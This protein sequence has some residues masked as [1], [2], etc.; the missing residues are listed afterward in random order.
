MSFPFAGTFGSRPLHACLWLALA[1]APAPFAATVGD[2]YDALVVHEWGTFTSVADENGNLVDWLPLTGSSDLPCFVNRLGARNIKLALGAVRMETPVLYF[3]SSRPMT[4]AVH[5][6]FPQGLITEWYPQAAKVESARFGNTGGRIQWDAVEL[7]PADHPDFPSG[8][9]ASHYYSARQ[10]DSA[11]ILI[12]QQQ[13]KM[14]FYRGMGNVP[15]PLQPHFTGG[16][17][18]EVRNSSAASIPLVI[19]FEN[20]GGKAG[21]KVARK[22][23]TSLTFDTNEF[24]ADIG[25]LRQEMEDNLVAQGLYP[26]EARAMLETWRESWFEEGTRIFYF[27]PRATVDSALPLTITPQPK[28]IARVFVGRIELLSPWLEENIEAA[29][30]IGDAPA[31]EKYGRFLQPFVNQISHKHASIVQ[32]QRSTAFLRSAYAKIQHEFDSPVCLE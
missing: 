30:T 20:R 10:T 13:E 21:Y 6:D 5:V 32:A 12:G 31:L 16:G 2:S 15:V 7:R 4:L 9:A 22:V 23:K 24:T 1:I 11:A 19:L 14:I 3:Y 18:L 25:R 27:V 28:D 8:K 26:K 17:K 29:L